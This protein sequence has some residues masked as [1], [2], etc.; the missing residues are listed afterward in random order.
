MTSDVL[1]RVMELT[2]SAGVDESGDPLPGG[3]T[4]TNLHSFPVLKRTPCGAWIED[5]HGRRRFVKLT[6]NKR[7]A[8]NTVE[9]AIAS[10]KARK[11]A[12]MRIYAAR[13][14][15]IMEAIRYLDTSGFYYDD[16]KWRKAA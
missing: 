15:A 7:Y 16:R 4:R 8:T 5:H 2:Y 12:E 6:A 13:S 3:P 9:E 10:F 1:Y 14:K 11:K